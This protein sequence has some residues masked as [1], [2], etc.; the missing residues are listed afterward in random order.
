MKILTHAP[1]GCSAYAFCHAHA[2]LLVPTEWFAWRDRMQGD[3][4]R[5]AGSIAAGHVPAK[6]RW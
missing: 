2:E 4:D 1:C 5:A 6:D 3:P